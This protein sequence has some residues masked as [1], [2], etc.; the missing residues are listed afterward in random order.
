MPPAIWTGWHTP[1]VHVPPPQEWAHAPQ[2][3]GSVCR[4]GQALPHFVVPA[5]VHVKVH[6]VPLQ[7]AVPPAGV[8]H[9]AHTLPQLSEP[10]GHW[11]PDD[12]QEPPLAHLV[13]QVPQFCGSLVRSSHVP[14]G[15]SVSPVLHAKLHPPSAHVGCACATDVVHACEQVPQLLG[16][17]CVSVQVEPQ[18]VCVDE[19]PLAHP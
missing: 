17:V 1:A 10:V 8:L 7:V 5:A 12:T 3:A 15:Q 18:S 13:P 16:S 2:L 19:H 11:Q 9:G 4:F 14:S 6:V